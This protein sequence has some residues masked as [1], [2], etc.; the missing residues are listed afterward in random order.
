M[1]A[2]ISTQAAAPIDATEAP[3]LENNFGNEQPIVAV[4]YS[5]LRR[6]PLNART[7]PLTGIPGLAANLAAKGLLRNLVV[8]ELR[9]WRC[10]QLELG[11]CDYNDD[12]LPAGVEAIDA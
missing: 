4:P 12:D 2:Q 5:C 11:V 1:E 6:S 8:P 3:L 9:G 7:K 10:K